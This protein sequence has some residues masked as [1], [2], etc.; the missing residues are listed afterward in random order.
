[1]GYQAEEVSV[2]SEIVQEIAVFSEEALGQDLS[3]GTAPD[4]WEKRA[5]FAM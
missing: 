3:Y 2:V 4:M 1:M 5:A